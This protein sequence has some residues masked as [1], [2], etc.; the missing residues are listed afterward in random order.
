MVL[1]VPTAELCLAQ[2]KLL[3][4]RLKDLGFLVDMNKSVFTPTQRIIFLGL[5]ID[6]VNIL[7][8]L[9]QRKNNWQ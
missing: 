3:M 1:I 4:K 8:F 5:V 2:G 9:F 6:S 7:Q